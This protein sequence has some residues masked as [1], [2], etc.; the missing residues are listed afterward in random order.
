MFS[1][2]FSPEKYGGFGRR[3]RNLSVLR[4]EERQPRVLTNGTQWLTTWSYVIAWGAVIFILSAQANL[5][6]PDSLPPSSDKVAHFWLYGVLGWLWA[7]AVT[8]RHPG[9][10]TV[11]VV[12]S[13]VAF[14]GLYGLSDEWHQAYVP[15]RCADLYDALADVC[16]GTLG[17]VALLLWLWFREESRTPARERVPELFRDPFDPA[18]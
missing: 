7:R 12:L 14:T 15:G 5:Q 9:W 1:V 3:G 2:S 10:T 13:A 8:A 16:G 18:A 4:V 6:L 17:G 11:A